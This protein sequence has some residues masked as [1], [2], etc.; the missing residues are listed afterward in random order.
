MHK[1]PGMD[2]VPFEFYKQLPFVALF[3]AYQLLLQRVLQGLPA[4]DSWRTTLHGSADGAVHRRVGKMG[5]IGRGPT[6]KNTCMR[7]LRVTSQAT[8][9]L[10]RTKDID[11]G[12]HYHFGLYSQADLWGRLLARAQLDIQHAHANVRP[13]DQAKAL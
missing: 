4:P 3:A 13:E 7:M 12:R 9:I 11:A 8:I 5:W 10:T 6:L 1:S 2:E